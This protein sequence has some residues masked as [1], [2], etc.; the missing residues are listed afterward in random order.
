M[1]ANEVV[2]LL[3]N[4]SEFVYQN[5]K[6]LLRKKIDLIKNHSKLSETYIRTLI[7]RHPDL[8]LK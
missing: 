1:K 6:D 5:K 8:F 2:E 4:F 3:D 7:R